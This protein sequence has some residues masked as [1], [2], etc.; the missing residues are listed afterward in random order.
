MAR[1]LSGK[2]VFI[3]GASRGIGH[4]IALRAARDGAN[5]VIAAKTDEKHPTLPGTIHSAARDVEGAGGKALAVKMDVRY[6]EQIDAAVAKAV[7]TFGGIDVLINN[8]GAI[9]LTRA[10]ETQMKRFDLMFDINVRGAYAM[11]RACLEA[12]GQAEN[13]HILN[14]SPPISMEPKW[15]KDHTAYTVSKYAMSMIAM[16]LSAECAAPRIG[17][18]ALWPR[19]A[20]ATSAL[21]MAS[22]PVDHKHTRKPAIMADAAHAVVTRDAGTCTGNF[23]TDEQVLRQEGVDDLRTYAVEPG[24]PLINDLFIN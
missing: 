15:F 9:N 3:T 4:A 21:I 14:I 18:N 2:T 8:A 20:I 5:V 13:P 19:T 12:L 16:G 6:E 1:T 17:V 24:E 23:F 10:P 22:G 11:S 7:D